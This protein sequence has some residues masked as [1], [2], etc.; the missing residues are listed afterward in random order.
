MISFLA[1]KTGLR[2][3][4]LL[5]VSGILLGVLFG[6]GCF[7]KS[8][9]ADPER[10][11]NAV[12]Q[13][14]VERSSQTTQA[15]EISLNE[16][17]TKQPMQA[18]PMV[19]DFEMGSKGSYKSATV[20]LKTGEWFF[21]EA[22]IGSDDRDRKNG[23]N[24]ARLRGLGKLTMLF[25]YPNGASRVSIKHG[26]YGNDEEGKW[27]LW[28]STNSGNSWRR[29]GTSVRASAQDLQTET[30]AVNVS[31]KVRF[32]IRAEL[33]EKSRIN[34]DDFVI[35]P[36]DDTAP[37]TKA[38]PPPASAAASIEAR[39]Q[40]QIELGMPTGASPEYIIRRPQYVISYNRD[41]NVANWACWH[42][43]AESFGPVP[44][45]QGN[46]LT[47]NSLPTGFYRVTHQDYTGSGYDRG[48]IVRSQER[49]ATR[50]DND[51]T[52][53]LTNI[54]PQTPD[55][56]QGVWN[57]FELYCEKLAKQQKELYLIAGGTFDKNPPR[58]KGKVTIPKSTWKIVVV[59]ERG[60]GL[61]DITK[62]TRVIAVDMPNIN[63]VRNDDWRKYRVSVAELERRTG[64]KFLTAV[65]EE[66]RKVL[67]EKVDAD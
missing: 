33:S 11:A 12:K 2:K 5:W 19:E 59:L 14:R 6:A 21:D 4:S 30:F 34:I 9:Q 40:K 7:S 28:L 26:V 31:G 23:N 46:F 64:L 57:A 49:T 43:N 66:V 54:L 25:D 53:Y 16:S 27:S 62:D 29:V 47:D 32:E 42:V 55:L 1:S 56:N 41:L 58:L 50:E 48:H 44:R 15:N 17:T 65:P 45:F 13:T 20:R 36:L 52:F 60:Q 38:E 37:Q 63:G 67:I 61:K 51:A 3:K 10:K 8:G 24:A 39:I 18:E 35:T 22:L